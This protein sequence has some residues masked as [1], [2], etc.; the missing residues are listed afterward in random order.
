MSNP[1][2]KQAPSDD[3]PTSGQTHPSTPADVSTKADGGAGDAAA[4]SSSSAFVE[5]ARQLGPVVG[6]IA[7]ISVTLPGI[8]G[9]TL[10]F[11]ASASAGSA[12]NF[13]DESKP[14]YHRL[15]GTW[16]TGATIA[17]PD[18]PEGRVYPEA[19]YEA[20]LE[21]LEDDPNA[22]APAPILEPISVDAGEIKPFKLAIEP[23][24]P[25]NG[26]WDGSVRSVRAVPL[27]IDTP[28]GVSRGEWEPYGRLAVRPGQTTLTLD[29]VLAYSDA[30]PK[31]TLTLE[32]GDDPSGDGL[33]V[34]IGGDGGADGAREGGPGSLYA[35][36]RRTP[37]A[38]ALMLML[39]VPLA[40][41]LVALAFA[42]V[43]G[44]AVL[45][46]Y[47]LSYAAGVFFGPVW[48]SLIAVGGVTGGAMVGYVWGTVLTKRRVSSVIDSNPRALVVRRAIVGKPLPKETLMVSLL[49]FPP[50]SPFA[51]TNLVMSSVGVR[52]LPYFIGTA[53]GI[54]PR[55]LAAVFLGVGVGSLADAQTAGGVW[56]VLI[57]I[58]VG[59]VVFVAAFY[60]LSK[61]A[62]D[63]LREE[64]GLS[65]DEELGVATRHEPVAAAGEA[66]V[67]RTGVPWGG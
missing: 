32:P 16:D 52:V 55:T 15:L 8:M 66:G 39:G 31:V 26:A 6:A 62:K 5:A 9:T 29:P 48:G 53:V 56:R 34:V 59:V 60:V 58:G 51:L 11:Y 40:A 44:S 21:A 37:P 30:L 38:Q 18:W 23:I 67:G 41:L 4:R 2:D 22:E 43:T 17:E 45:P 47:A 27:V 25:E 36:E 50:N 49:R 7:L 14:G 1:G 54:A 3:G 10:I 24:V 35:G 65:E 12:S 13:Y 63:A 33:S 28:P 19:A 57:G 20:H 64:A 46:T 42:A 61:W